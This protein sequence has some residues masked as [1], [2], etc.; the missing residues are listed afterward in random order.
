MGRKM[1]LVFPFLCWIYCV[2][3]LSISA[4]EGKRG[5]GQR[6][7]GIEEGKREGNN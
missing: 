5:G 2:P 3:T 6:E 1:D 4:K 7:E